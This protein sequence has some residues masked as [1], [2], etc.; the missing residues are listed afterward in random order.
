MRAKVNFTDSSISSE[1]IKSTW[2]KNTNPNFMITIGCQTSKTLYDYK[3]NETQSGKY[4]DIIQNQVL[5][6]NKGI[7]LLDHFM[8][9]NIKKQKRSMEQWKASILDGRVTVDC[10]TM[11]DPTMKVDTEYFIEYVH[12]KVNVG[13]QTQVYSFTNTIDNNNEISTTTSESKQ[14]ESKSNRE[15]KTNKENKISSIS[16]DLLLKF[17][18]KIEPLVIK[19]LDKTAIQSKV[20]VGYDFTSALSLKDTMDDKISYWKCLTVDLEKHKVIYPDWSKANHFKGNIINNNN[21]YIAILFIYI[22][23]IIIYIRS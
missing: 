13:T 21:I 19:E 9:V 1:T 14:T 4:T 7:T 8:K 18:N 3:E 22:Y 16:N 11:T 20:F 6:E 12:D 17:L 10:E 2:K 15:S 5:D 23:I